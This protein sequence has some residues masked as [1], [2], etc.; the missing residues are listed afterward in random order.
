MGIFAITMLLLFTLTLQTTLKDS[1]ALCDCYVT[2]SSDY[3]QYHRFYLFQSLNDTNGLYNAEPANIS[4][5]QSDGE[6]AGQ[7]GYLNTSAFANAWKINNWGHNAGSLQP[8]KL[9]N[10]KQNVY[11]RSSSLF[12]KVI[13]LNLTPH[14]DRQ[15]QC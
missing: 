15:R 12:F 4:R 11:I 1:S 5:F 14:R 7:Q 13:L 2:S 8:V 9:Q 3:F 6:E 10:S